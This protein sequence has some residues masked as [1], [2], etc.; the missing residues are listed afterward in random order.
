MGAIESLIGTMRRAWFHVAKGQTMSEETFVTV[1]TEVEAIVNGRPLTLTSDDPSDPCPL[2]PS[3][4]L[5]LKGIS[6]L[7]PGIFDSK[8]VFHR[9]WKQTQF[10]VDEF[11]KRFQVE[12]VS[13]LHQ[14]T[15]W[16]RP[17][18]D[19]KV[20]DFVLIVNQH[21]PR[22]SWQVGIVS[23]TFDGIDGHVR[24]VELKTTGGQI[25]R[26]IGKLVLLEAVN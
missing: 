14:R 23:Q 1:A 21:Q 24:T 7:A 18:R 17:S 12:Y 3:H 9:R 10:I 25:K 26:S 8:D 20:G 11:W 13:T 16:L 6:T 5:T 15:K 2:T 19:L 22:G 4:L